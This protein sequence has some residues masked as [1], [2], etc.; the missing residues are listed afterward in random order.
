MN[1]ILHFVLWGNTIL[2]YAIAIACVL[3]AWIVL[4]LIKG[5][6]L[7]LVKK[8]ASRSRTNLDDLLVDITE[9]FVLPYVYLLINSS[10]I[11]A[12]TLSPVVARVV[13]AA[14]LVVT[15]YYA[16]RLINFFI[17]HS[18]VGFMKRKNE[19]PER[20][21]QVSSMLLLVK[22]LTWGMG[23]IMLADNLGYNVTT[24]IAGLG[25]GGIAI[26]LAAQNILGDLFSYFVIFFDKPFEIGDFIIVDSNSGVVEK[27]GIKT[28][29]VRSLDGQQLVMPNAEMVKSVI[30]NYKRLERRRVVFSIGVVYATKAGKL[31][32][33]P[34]IVKDIITSEEH[35][36]FDRA[37]LK[38]FGDFSINFEF[39][40]YIE[41]P[42]YLLYMNIQ[43]AICLHIFEQ[44][45]K[46]QIEF[47]FPTQTLFVT[48]QNEVE[49]KLMHI[50]NANHR[51]GN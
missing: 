50:A 44:F 10:I 36:T 30:Q 38:G 33:I 5:K 29:H 25:V 41:S 7:G 1:Q 14:F 49:H 6:L 43:Q 37:H 18:V 32:N 11:K 26:A 8:L 34:A 47:A 35:T 42:D 23:L 20:I 13:T 27:I 46:E 45:E 21:K 12:L 15:T 51:D 9:R 40:Y 2:Q 39:V 22:V 28:S 3:V 4:K 19:P 31:K 16:V 24:I 17:Q 48:N